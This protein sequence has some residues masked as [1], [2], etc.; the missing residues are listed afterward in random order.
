MYNKIAVNFYLHNQEDWPTIHCCAE[1]IKTCHAGDQP[2][3]MPVIFSPS[4]VVPCLM[5]RVS[6]TV[7]AFVDIWVLTGSYIQLAKTI[8]VV[9]C[10]VLTCDWTPCVPLVIQ[11]LHVFSIVTQL[12][13][14]HFI[15]VTVIVYIL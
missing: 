7:L 14:V 6:A 5:E 2:I 11:V 12:T 9:A 4:V 10:L 13:Q 1:P 15:I 8:V 3:R